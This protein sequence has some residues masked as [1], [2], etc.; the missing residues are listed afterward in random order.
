MK[1]ATGGLS[2][3]STLSA[4]DLPG[5]L[6]QVSQIRNFRML[7]KC[8]IMLF[9]VDALH[10]AQAAIALGNHNSQQF[11]IKVTR[12]IQRAVYYFLSLQ[13]SRELECHS[14]LGVVHFERQVHQFLWSLR[15]AFDCVCKSRFVF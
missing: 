3:I 5:V 4:M 2:S 9:R 13:R 14:E 7:V 12:Q 11:P 1:K 8:N 10:T 15:V 6:L